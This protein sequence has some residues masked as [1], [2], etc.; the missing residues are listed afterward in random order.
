[1]PLRICTRISS[2][3]CL[4]LLYLF[5]RLLSSLFILNP[6]CSCLLLF[7]T[8]P[9]IYSWCL[10][11][12]WCCFTLSLPG[13]S[14]HQLGI[15]CL[16]I[17]R[18]CSM[19]LRICTR[20]SSNRCLLLL[21]LFYRLLSSCFVLD[22]QGSCLLLFRS[23]ILKLIVS[24][25]HRHWFLRIEIVGLAYLQGFLF[26]KPCLSFRIRIFLLSLT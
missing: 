13:L 25:L 16:S 9:H 5:Y 10:L 23:S 14:S 12:C 21:Y 8:S 24:E 2:N 17:L 7:S 11:C 26:R 22:L 1:M 20:I 6:Q 3:R 4:L 15:I 18:P 19:P